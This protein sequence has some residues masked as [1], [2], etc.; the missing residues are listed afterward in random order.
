MYHD[1]NYEAILASSL[2]AQWLLDDVL[3]ADQELDFSRRFMPE[4]LARTAALEALNAE[5]AAH[6][7]PDQRHQYLEHL[8]PGR[9]VHPA[10][11]ARSCAAE[12]LRRRLPRPR[13]AQLRRRGSQAHPSVPALPRR[14]RARLPAACQ[15]IGPAEAIGAEVLRH[16]PLAVG[17]ASSCMIE[18]MTQQ[19]YLDS[20]RDDGDLDPLFKS[21]M[22]ITGWRRRSTPSSTP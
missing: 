5:R 3:R 10:V 19:H 20:V 13:A 1:F 18:W 15:V 12:L 9:G 2:R 16:D 6:P 21:L 7:Q 22:R 14:L 4:S 17:A 11:R 8:R